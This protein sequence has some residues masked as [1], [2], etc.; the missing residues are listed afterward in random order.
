MDFLISGA[1]SAFWLGILTSL[2]PCPLATNI[3]AISFISKKLHSVRAVLL[4]GILY[5][6]GRMITYVAVA[7]L[8][9]I[10]LSSIPKLS[11]ILQKYMNMILGPALIITGMFL[12][13]LLSSSFS[14]VG[15][16]KR[17]KQIASKGSYWSAGLLGILFA[18][19]FC[20]VTAAIF[21]GSLIPLSLNYNSNIILPA[22]FGIG[23]GLP[24]FLFAV[25]ISFSA[26]SI[27]LIYKK[28]TMI[29]LWARRITGVLLILIGIYLV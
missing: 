14:S 11:Y 5:T 18:L 16:D 12:L 2:S 23:T 17:A 24:V 27:N 8:V 9:I 20:P 29:E 22:L 15:S 25:V 6:I 13:E 21:F 7:V 10:G 3:A 4:S 19:S 26:K 28:V 1:V